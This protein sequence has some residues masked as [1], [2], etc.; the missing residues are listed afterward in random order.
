[1]VPLVVLLTH[2]D[3]CPVYTGIKTPLSMWVNSSRLDRTAA[4]LQTIVSSFKYI[5]VN[6]KFCI[7]M[8]ISLKFIP[9]GPFDNNTAFV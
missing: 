1:M 2:Y 7:L 6:G 9:K 5:F 3:D 8:E 4:I